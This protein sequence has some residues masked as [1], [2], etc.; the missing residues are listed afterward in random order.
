MADLVTYAKANPGKLNYGSSGLAGLTHYAV[1]LFQAR[2][3]T[4]MNHIPYKTG[5][6][7]VLAIVSGEVDFAFGNMTDAL[8][9]IE[10][11]T[12]RALAV[13]SL[14]RSPYFPDLPSV[15]ETISPGFAVETWNG[16]M[17]PA[18]T[19]EPVI[20]RMSEV[21]MKMANDPEVKKAMVKAGANTVRTTPEQ[22]AQQIQDEIAQWKPLLAEITTK[23]Q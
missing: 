22:Y 9:Q 8:P 18:Q 10:A 14:G 2:T 23:K 12:V 5:A 15:H 3:S 13:T 6:Q 4:K 11:G 1:E 17:A 7:G 20:R 16:L 19:P 21:L